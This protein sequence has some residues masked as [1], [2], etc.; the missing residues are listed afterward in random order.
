MQGTSNYVD[1]LDLS[2]LAAT[3]SRIQPGARVRVR[4]AAEREGRITDFTFVSSAT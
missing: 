1:D 3:Q 4:F 2:D